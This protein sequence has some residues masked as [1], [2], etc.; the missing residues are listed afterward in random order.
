MHQ[1]RQEAPKMLPI[2]RKGTKYVVRPLSNTRNSV[3]VVMAT[4]DILRLAKTTREVKAMIHH[5]MLK[6][7]GR[8]VHDV[9]ESIKLFNIFEAGKSYRLSILPTKKFVL[10]ET[11]EKD[12]R[13][14]KVISRKL[15]SQGKIQINMHDGSNLI[16]KD[17]INVGDTVY[18]DFSGKVKKHISLEKG[19]D[20]FVFSGK[21]SGC[22]GKILEVSGKSVKLNINGKE[23]TVEISESQ[24]IVT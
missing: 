8:V 13:I 6:L 12:S 19:R 18:L 16:T 10:E 2:P 9:R 11:K 4:R 7:N 23:K 22:K 14:C 15:I 20:V 5:K 21:Y 1:T 17:K 24:L 3:S